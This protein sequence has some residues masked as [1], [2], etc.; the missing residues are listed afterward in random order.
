M[1]RANIQPKGG[2]RMNRSNVSNPLLYAG[3]GFFYAALAGVAVSRFLMFQTRNSIKTA[4]ENVLLSGSTELSQP[5]ADPLQYH[6]PT[7]PTCISYNLSQSNT[8][9]FLKIQSE[10]IDS[11][12]WLS[13]IA[14][15]GF[16]LVGGLLGLMYGLSVR[17]RYTA[18]DIAP[19]TKSEKSAATIDNPRT[20]GTI[21]PTNTPI[22]L[23]DADP[24]GDATVHTKIGPM[25]SST[26]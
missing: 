21:S 1:L 6:H 18:S 19:E 16:S 17:P 9:S 14:L 26:V 5:Q 22:I 11:Y 15:V 3:K 13:I 25:S 20:Y 12:A 2:V 8:C 10:A 7:A 24:E 23:E 4:V